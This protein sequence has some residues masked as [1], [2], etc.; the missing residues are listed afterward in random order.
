MAQKSM[1]QIENCILFGYGGGEHPKCTMQHMLLSLC[2]GSSLYT[3]SP[4][5]PQLFNISSSWVQADS[6]EWLCRLWSAA[7][8]R[9]T[10][11]GMAGLQNC[12]LSN[13]E[14]SCCITWIGLAVVKAFISKSKHCWKSIFWF[15]YWITCSKTVL[16]STCCLGT[17]QN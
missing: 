7:P 13:M 15:T 9:M 1:L 5:V 4:N 12:S 17:S 6:S 2:L 10:F 14:N 16:G 3:V 11:T 8:S